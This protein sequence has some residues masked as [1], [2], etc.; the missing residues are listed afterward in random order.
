MYL[1]PEDEFSCF[2]IAPVYRIWRWFS[3]GKE[4]LANTPPGHEDEE[5]LRKAISMFTEKED[6]LQKHSN[7]LQKVNTL[8]LINSALTGANAAAAFRPSVLDTR[9][10]N[11]AVTESKD[12]RWRDKAYT[13][14]AWCSYCHGVILSKHKTMKCITCRDCGL[15]VHKQ[16]REKMPPRCG[17]LDQMRES[18]VQQNRLF[19]KEGTATYSEETE[20]VITR[21]PVSCR[22]LLFSDC[23]L[24]VCKASSVGGGK[25]NLNLISIGF[26]EGSN[27]EVQSSSRYTVVV[28]FLIF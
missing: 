23:I 18:L 9:G 14:A 19:L 4:L 26:C 22:L 6:I 3:I 15:I 16:C 2:L 28:F 25:V 27:I 13:T 24:C 5:E 10:S 1:N 7:H 11:P 17:L 21:A 12:H 8:Y 20:G